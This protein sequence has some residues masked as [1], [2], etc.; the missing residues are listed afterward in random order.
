MLLKDLRAIRKKFVKIYNLNL[1][2]Q[3]TK[4]M[5]NFEAFGLPNFLVQSLERMH[6]TKPTPIQAQSIGPAMTGKDIL[7][8]AQT[9]TG[10]TMS[11]LLPLVSNM[12]ASKTSTALILT[13]T[14]ELAAQVRDAISQ[15]FNSAPP[16]RSALLIGGDP[17]MKQFAA[18]KRQP[19][20]IVGTPGRVIDHL[21]RRTLD[22]KETAFLVLDETDRMLDMGFTEP[23]K[24]IA[25]MLPQ[26]RQTMM[27]SATMPPS[28][29]AMSQKYLTD[30]VHIKVGSTIEPI[31]KIKQE[32]IQIQHGQKFTHLL[33]ELD[34]REGSVIIFVK[35]KHSADSLALKLKGQSHNADA[36][37]GDLRQR[38]REQVIASFRNQ[39]S[40]I[41]V[42][43]DIAARGLDVPHVMHVINYDLPQCPHDYIHRIGR[44]GRAG[45]EGFALSMISPDDNSKW[46]AIGKLIS[47][48]DIDPQRVPNKPKGRSGSGFGGGN[49]RSDD[50]RSGGGFGDRRPSG[51]FGANNTRKS[52]ERKP[53]GGFGG[54]FKG[55]ANSDGAR[56][57]DGKPSG[58]KKSFGFGSG[59]KGGAVSRVQKNAF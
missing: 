36:I 41:M 3:S 53:G 39:K 40:R 45:A 54:G 1:N 22:L 26:Q 25:S 5:Q 9:G 56:R 2:I 27:F 34:D 44:T 42:A 55:G 4:L 31:A 35:T 57:F 20:I 15:I 59:P 11:Y 24:K 49:R 28:I 7:A 18:L 21:E 6:I 51:G 19:R 8:S 58:P 46:R 52:G 33:K 48:E 14:R 30:P 16:F 38:R 47:G 23:L 12:M 10:K 17:I 43:T 37:H 50:R 13:P 32:S 29:I